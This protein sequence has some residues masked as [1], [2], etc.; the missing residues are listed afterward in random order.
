MVVKRG[1]RSLPVGSLYWVDIFG[2]CVNLDRIES[3]LKG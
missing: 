3:E 2:V 1:G